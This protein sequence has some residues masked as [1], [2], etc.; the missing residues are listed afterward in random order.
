M[1]GPYGGILRVVFKCLHSI[2]IL[3][4]TRN[5]E[6]SS[7]VQEFVYEHVC[8][9]IA[10]DL[11]GETRKDVGRL[12]VVAGCTSYEAN[13]AAGDVVGLRLFLYGSRGRVVDL[14]SKL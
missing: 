9:G 11:Q 13:F 3:G 12:M 1:W 7:N 10:S 4:F 6:S 2:H 5:V 8:Q 14:K